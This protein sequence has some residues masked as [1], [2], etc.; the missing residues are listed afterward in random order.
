MKNLKIIRKTIKVEP[1]KVY[2]IEVEDSHHYFLSNGI[3]SHNSVGSFIPMDVMSGGGG[4]LYNASF[5]AGLYKS[6]LAEKLDKD[7]TVENVDVK[8]TGIIVRSTVK[9]GRFA[10]PITIRFHISF[11]KGMNPYVGLEDYISWKNCGIERGSIVTEKELK[12]LPEADQK[13]SEE[14]DVNGKKM[15][16]IPKAK[17]N[18]YVVKHLGK[19]VK[20]SQLFTPEVFTEDVLKMLDEN[21]IKPTFMLPEHC[22][23]Y[24]VDDFVDDLIEECE[25]DDNDDNG[26][27]LK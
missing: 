3:L 21:I 23:I 10:R 8:S 20:S 4:P 24:E 11:Y 12:K 27:D 7:E 15:Y 2:D 19:V 6:K 13:K 25:D 18:F 17:A 26:L 1:I 16:F 9:K 22:D 5:I 14:F